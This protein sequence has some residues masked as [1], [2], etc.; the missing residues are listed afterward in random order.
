M[1]YA[2]NFFIS[3]HAVCRTHL[4]HFSC[5]IDAGQ[6]KMFKLGLLTKTNSVITD[7][8]VQE[9]FLK[10]LRAMKDEER[11]PERFCNLLNGSL[12]REIPNAPASV[13][14]KTAMRWM[15]VLNFGLK[16]QQK[17]YYTDGHN[18]MM[19]LHI[20]TIRFYLAWWT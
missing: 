5:I 1:P 11:T 2:V 15:R 13:T 6:L 20:G 10:E 8:H 9:I 14:V 18:R 19:S 12:L 16:L 3:S 7:E 17:G 4:L